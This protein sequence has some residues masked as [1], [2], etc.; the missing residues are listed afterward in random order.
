MKDKKITDVIVIVD[1]E[2]GGAGAIRAEDLD[3]R[4]HSVLKASEILKMKPNNK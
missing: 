4:V 2:S 3:L 1:R